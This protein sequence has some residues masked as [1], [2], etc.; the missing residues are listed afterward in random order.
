MIPCNC[1]LLI[2]VR[3]R[4]A[5]ANQT[6]PNQQSSH[7]QN[8]TV[9]KLGALIIICDGH[10]TYVYTLHF[11]TC[12]TVHHCSRAHVCTYIRA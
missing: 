9:I 5:A 6:K 3:C 1:L 2:T 11:L 10:T 7:V 12:T 4:A 8:Q